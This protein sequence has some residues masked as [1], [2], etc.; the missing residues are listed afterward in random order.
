[1]RLGLAKCHLFVR[2]A[3]A[4]CGILPLDVALDRFDD[5]RATCG[6]AQ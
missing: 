3:L 6:E 4:W 2:I 5:Q 1:V